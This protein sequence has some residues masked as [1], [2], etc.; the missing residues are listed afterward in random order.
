MPIW[1][2][3]PTPEEGNAMHENTLVEQLDSLCFTDGTGTSTPVL[4]FSEPLPAVV[5]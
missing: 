5:L 2:K 1:F 4:R 3:T